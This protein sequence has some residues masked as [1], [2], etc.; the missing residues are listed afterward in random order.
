MTAW[1][2]LKDFPNRVISLIWNLT[3]RWGVALG[4]TYFL[5]TRG[6]VDNWYAAIVWIVFLLF[7]LFKTE[8]PEILDRILKIKE[9]K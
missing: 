6:V 3:S 9:L 5:I 8:A 2:T 1:E 4:A 7:Y